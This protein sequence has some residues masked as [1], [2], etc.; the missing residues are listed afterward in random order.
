[1]SEHNGLT[2]QQAEELGRQNHAAL[3]SLR[4]QWG[5]WFRVSV[6]FPD[7]WQ[8]VLAADESVVLTASS[9]VHLGDKMSAE[10]GRR[11]PGG[12]WDG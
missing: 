8:A 10:Y 11:L 5:D 3:Q 12:D 4:A 9:A 2:S 7:Y 1:M 6:T